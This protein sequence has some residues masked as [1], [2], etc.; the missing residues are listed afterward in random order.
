MSSVRLHSTLGVNPRMMVCPICGEAG[1]I[2]LLGAKNYIDECP[3]CG[4]KVIGGIKEQDRCPKCDRYWDYGDRGHHREHLADSQQYIGKQSH[5]CSKCEAQMK[6]HIACFRMVK[7]PPPEKCHMAKKEPQFDQMVWMLDDA[8]RRI[9]SGDI[10]DW[11]I[12]HRRAYMPPSVW[13]QV[14]LAKLVKEHE[15]KQ[16]PDKDEAPGADS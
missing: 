1:D 13:E 12:K 6:T 3:G 8:F 7:E 10:V 4:L 14:G 9:F 2:V 15:E 11:S 5:P 16:K